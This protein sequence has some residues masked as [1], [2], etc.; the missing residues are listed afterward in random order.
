MPRQKTVKKDAKKKTADGDMGMALVGLAEE[1]GGVGE[2]LRPLHHIETMAD[3]IA[4]LAN[5]LHHLANATALSVIAQH[6]T[7]EDRTTVVASLKRWFDEFRD[8]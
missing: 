6:G 5:A 8:R 7:D 1:L 2:E 4:E 3:N